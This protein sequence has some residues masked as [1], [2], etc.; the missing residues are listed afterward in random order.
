[1]ILL[2]T[3]PVFSASGNETPQVGESEANLGLLQDFAGNDRMLEEYAGQGKWLVVMLW[4]SYCRISNANIDAYNTFYQT[5]D[6]EDL[7]FVGVSLDGLKGKDDAKRFIEKHDV[8]FPNLLGELNPVS[9][10][11]AVLTGRF[12][13]STPS[14]LIFS[15]DGKLLAQQ[16]GAVPPQLIADFID[17]QS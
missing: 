9:A 4:T 8:A 11:Y 5:H 10:F 3:P 13:V 12:A 14:F 16:S 1:V 2:L 6:L 15:P 17:S 7:E